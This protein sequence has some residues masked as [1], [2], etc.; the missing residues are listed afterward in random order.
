MGQERVVELTFGKES[1]GSGYLVDRRHVFTARHVVP[2]NTKL[3][4]ACKAQ[5]LIGANPSG[6]S[7]GRRPRPVSARIVWLP[8]DATLDIAVVVLDKPADVTDGF[9]PMG[10]IRL[11]EPDTRRVECTGFPSAAGESSQRVVGL[12]SEVPDEGRQ[13]LDVTSA[14]PLDMREWSGLSGALVFSGAVAIGV[15]ATVH[16]GYS[17]KLTATPLHRLFE[18]AAF[19][20]WW[21]GQG[22]SLELLQ[23][24]SPGLATSDDVAPNEIA[25]HLHWLDRSDTYADARDHLR[26]KGVSNRRVVVI[27]GM[28]QD[29]HHNFIQRLG[30][31]NE[32]KRLLDRDAPCHEIFVELPWPQQD[33]IK[34]PDRALRELLRPL[35]VAGGIDLLRG[36]ETE[37]GSD[38]DIES[39]SG[40]IRHLVARLG[41]GTASR[42]YW[43][44]LRRQQ[45]HG[46]HGAL[47]QR[48]LAFWSRLK[49]QQP[50]YLF[51]CVT[52]DDFPPPRRS[53]LSFLKAPPPPETD[54]DDVLAAA[55]EALPD[56]HEEL[57][58]LQEIS[59]HHVT[60]WIAELKLRCPEL[61][62]ETL[63]R[64]GAALQVH[65]GLHSMG[66]RLAPVAAELG[67]IYRRT[68]C[69]PAGR[70]L[71]EGQP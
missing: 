8:E 41:D 56:R 26:R 34:H 57:R 51:L 62:G 50:V 2:N 43:T 49:C 44:L 38:V 48:L 15:V 29:V 18:D 9:V 42:A 16:S 36:S 58:G 17:G 59:M 1:Q 27:P 6:P 60:P 3:G 55:L 68:M 65:L 45:A 40:D 20:R 33:T 23:L 69:G 46:G 37:S 67:P 53:I 39:D 12:L 61:P 7:K 25:R 63:D 22:G 52:L 28:E 66:L 14:H 13:D 11:G 4:H 31:S 70:R 54:L 35:L 71:N 5:F 21:S 24:Q 19:C 47:V 10:R 32:I 30:E 64:F